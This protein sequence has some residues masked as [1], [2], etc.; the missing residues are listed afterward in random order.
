MK[1]LL[2]VDDEQIVREGLRSIITKSFPK[3]EIEE[4]R[5]GK[6]ALEMAAV[7][8]P[9]IILIDIKMPGMSGLEVIEKINE[10]NP[11]IKY[12]M[13]TA[14]AEFDYAQSALK[15]GVK[16]YL[17]KP[18]KASEIMHTVGRV[19]E[20]INEEKKDKERQILQENVLEKALYIVET[21]VVTQLLFDHVHE[22][23]LDELVG[24]LNTPISNENFVMSIQLP[25][26]SESLYKEIKRKVRQ[27]ANVWVGVLYGRQ[28]PL[29]VFKEQGKTFRSQAVKLAQEI[30][31]VSNSELNADWFIGIGNVCD[32]L[33][34][35]R[36]SYQE[37]LLAMRIISPTVRYSFYS[38]RTKDEMR[39]NGYNSK[40]LENKFFEQIRSGKW[41]DLANEILGLI[42]QFENSE[43]KLVEAYQRVLE[44][45]WVASRVLSEIGVEPRTPLYPTQIKNYRQLHTETKHLLSGMQRAFADYSSGVKDDIIQQI[46]YYIVE[47]SHK[48]ISLERIANKFELSPIYISKLFKEQLGINYINYL[49]ECRLEKARKL[50][51]DPKK[52]LKEITFE[53]G[54]HDPNYFSKVFKKIYGESPTEFRKLFQGQR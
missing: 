52:S 25:E 7:F 17:L 16:D 43:V 27:S 40:E 47:N 45:L 42:G 20:Q 29:I 33:D 39:A 9:D 46:K 14:Y 23:H 6:I 37:S 12:I 38:D 10:I 2:I 48:D 31:K 21:D 51:T 32:S 22:V 19:M 13:I 50:M 49:T 8:H 26:N 44:M 35:I 3:V 28:I 36:Q 5:N 53:V 41:E 54:Y 24:L 1:K 15:L 18:S 34:G 30:L 11:Y 4:A